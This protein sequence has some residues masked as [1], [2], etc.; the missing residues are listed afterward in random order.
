MLVEELLELADTVCRLK[1]ETQTVEVK[2]ARERLP[3][4]IVRYAFQF[5]QS[6]QR[7]HPVVLVLTKRPGFV[8][9]GVYDLQD[10]QKRVTEQ[11]NQMNPRCVLSLR[12]QNTKE[13]RS[14]Q[15]KYLRWI[16]RSV[17]AITVDM[18]K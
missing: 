12:L 16:W 4:P 8:P 18:G 15:Q 14:A 6:G 3:P 1:A 7:R 10:L 5:F 13:S 9:V 17:P 11:C 2:S